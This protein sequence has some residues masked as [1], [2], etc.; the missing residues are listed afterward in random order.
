VT[1]EPA[2]AAAGGAGGAVRC[3]A[4][5]G[6]MFSN[7]TVSWRTKAATR[8]VLMRMPASGACEPSPKR[9]P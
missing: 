9:L 5:T 4:G 1:D 8:M 6:L 7:F 2:L 3:S